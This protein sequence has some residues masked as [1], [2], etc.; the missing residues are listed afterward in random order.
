MVKAQSVNGNVQ[1]V[2]GFLHLR[3]IFTHTKTEVDC[4]PG[5]STE[6]VKKEKKKKATDHASGKRKEQ[7]K[8][9]KKQTNQT[10]CVPYVD[11]LSYRSR[12]CLSPAP[13]NKS[14][15]VACSLEHCVHRRHRGHCKECAVCSYEFTSMRRTSSATLVVLWRV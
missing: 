10:L 12:P 6:V 1:E 8:Q 14:V 7:R 15:L 2:S 5:A 9:K 13:E 3:E 11:C 4:S